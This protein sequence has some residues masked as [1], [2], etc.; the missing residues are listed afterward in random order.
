MRKCV[1]R[2]NSATPLSHPCQT[3]S[4]GCQAMF[5]E[6]FFCIE[7]DIQV[8][9]VNFTRKFVGD[10]SFSIFVTEKSEVVSELTA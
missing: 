1:S 9:R 3:A 7:V 8:N 6:T 2:R 10:V 4:R 5:S